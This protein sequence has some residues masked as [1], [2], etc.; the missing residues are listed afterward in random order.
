[1]NKTQ[2]N[3]AGFTIIEIIVAVGLFTFVVI[4]A[5]GITISVT[6]AERKS[7]AI[8]AV[9]DNIRFSL[10]L[11]TKE[12]RTGS[13]FDLSTNCVSVLGQEITF[14]STDAAVPYRTYYLQ[15]GTLKRIKAVSLPT[16]CSSAQD[17]TSPNEVFVDVLAFNLHNASVV[18][19]TECDG[20]P[21]I[22]INMRLHSSEV[23][24]GV[25]TTMSLQTTI[26]QRLRDI[27]GVG[28]GSSC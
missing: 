12:M 4:Y 16:G 3:K 26:V 11:I 18:Q 6:R 2:K 19:A 21:T 20:Q 24:Y 15:N 7:S 9:Q 10:E 1:M 23:L 25:A 28:G 8:Q 13:E 22:V 27:G 14:R 5:I 17:L